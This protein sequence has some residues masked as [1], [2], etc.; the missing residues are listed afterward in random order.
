MPG[1]SSADLKASHMLR[2]LSN[3][4]S[5]LCLAALIAGVSGGAVALGEHATTERNHSVEMIDG[6]GVL[7]APGLDG[8][9][10]LQQSPNDNPGKA[11][12]FGSAFHYD[13]FV[14]DKPA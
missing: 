12:H 10:D 1:G 14:Y 9:N 2:F 11:G 5:L 13:S 4:W 8:W 6:Q 3:R 7:R